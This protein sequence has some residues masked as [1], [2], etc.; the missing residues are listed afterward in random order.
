ML[1]QYME[2]REGERERERER[3]SERERERE[4]HMEAHGSTHVERVTQNAEA[5]RGLKSQRRLGTNP[6]LARLSHAGRGE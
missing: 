1:I 6:V 4:M 2:G 5:N 3:E